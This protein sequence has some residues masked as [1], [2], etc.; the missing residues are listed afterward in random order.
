MQTIESILDNVSQYPAKELAS[1]INEGKV[2]M[3]DLQSS[4]QFP[5]KLQQ[6]VRQ[7]LEKEEEKKVW[8]AAVKANKIENYQ[9]YLNQYP[10]GNYRDIANNKMSSLQ[11]KNEYKDEDKKVI[12]EDIKKKISKNHNIISDKDFLSLIK[13]G[14]ITEKDFD[15]MKMPKGLLE[16]MKKQGDQSLP[17]AEPLTEIPRQSVE[18]YFWGIPSSGKTCALGAILSTAKNGDGSRSMSTINTCQGYA[19]MER[20]SAIFSN[21][22]I[23]LLPAGTA[24]N[25]TY[26]MAFDLQDAKKTHPITCVDLAGELILAMYKSDTGDS[27]NLNDS[28]KNTLATV[29]NLLTDK[30]SSNRKMHF[31]VIEY[32]AEKREYNGFKQSDCL[33]HALNYIKAKQIF[34]KDTD[35]IFILLTKADLIQAKG[36]ELAKKMKTYIKDN[37]GNF[38][39]LLKTICN[40]HGINNGQVEVIPFSVGDVWF[41]KYCKYNSKYAE[42]IVNEIFLKRC[43]PNASVWKKILSK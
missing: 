38:Y 30:R 33:A 19:Y 23:C 31:F 13:N 27:L 11:N 2:T 41:Q 28:M 25:A 24:E 6:E 10:H 35:G 42:Y 17:P 9:E 22:Q 26:E 8:N 37:Y 39:N 36:A 40:D 20:L 3:E 12:V 15:E 21:Q 1:Y 7:V 4:G 32:G 43:K 18:I 14:Q 29:N 16:I 34:E 5:P